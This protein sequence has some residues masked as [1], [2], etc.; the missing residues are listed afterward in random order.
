M[1]Y[2]KPN[3]TTGAI[4]SLKNHVFTAAE[5]RILPNDSRNVICL[6]PFSGPPA[7]GIYNIYAEF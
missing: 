5:V 2:F 3:I 7:I 1:G 4:L 6:N